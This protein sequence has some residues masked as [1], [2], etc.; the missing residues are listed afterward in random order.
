MT[1][2]FF[3][4]LLGALS[5]LLPHPPNFVPLGAL[6]L[7]AGARL[8]RRWALAVPLAS[9]VVSDFFLDFGA[10]RALITPVRVAVYAT[11]AAMVLIGRLARGEASAARLLVLTVGS[12]VAFFLTTNLAVFLGGALYPRTALGL[13][14][15]Y[16]A[17]V[18]FFWSTLLADLC[19]TGLFFGLDAFSR[20][21]RTRGT[22]RAAAMAAAIAL[23]GVAGAQ[24]QPPVSAS[25]IVTATMTEEEERELGS[26]ATVITRER[27]E[28]SGARTVVELLREV[29]GL[30]VAQQG[31]DGALTS[32]FLR[33]AN[34][35]HLLVLVDGARMNS[36]YFS[37]YDFSSLTTENIERIE[38]VRGPFSALYGSDAIGG[39]VQ[40]F[41]RP[42]SS[43]AAGRATLEGGEQGQRRLSA[44]LSAGEGPFGAAASYSDARSNGPRTNSDWGER[45]GTLRI[46]WRGDHG[47]RVGME[48][49]IRE[50]E[51][52]VPGPVG[53]ESPRAR[54]EDREERLQIPVAFR[55]AAGH[56]ASLLFARVAS[57]RRFENPDF[58]FRS[59]SSPE[60]LQARGTDTFRAG[61]H[62]MTAFASWERGR[63][64]DRSNFG[65]ALDD[66][67]STLWGAGLQDILP[68]ARGLILTAG[69][70][71][72]R[73]SDFGDAWSPRAT[74]AWFDGAGLWKARASAG[75]AFRAPSVGE[76]F[77]PFSGNPDLEPERVTSY[78]AGVERFLGAGGASLG[79]SL[80]W[81]EFRNLIVYE[82]FT[83]LNANVGRARTRGAEVVARAPLGPRAEVNAAY[84][85][86][87][88][89][90]RQTGE[91][92]LRRPRHRASASIAWQPIS[93]WTL[94]P[95]VVFVGRRADADPVT[96]ARVPQPSFL[97]LD[98]FTRYDFGLLEAYARVENLAD[99]PY[100]EVRGYPASG[101]RFSGG[102]EVRF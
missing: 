33:G 78:E 59:Q 82:F 26:A 77:Y 3:L 64:N 90:D 47:L 68:L 88:A 50:S 31:S 7:Y 38:V 51:V 45:S 61:P 12:S 54:Q 32:V 25:V 52:G 10:G 63:V 40:I 80:F 86:L 44:F 23:P 24:S 96:R 11:F 89:E 60:T 101:R 66:H 57:E 41:T 58:D 43:A 83:S 15:C 13:A 69:M 1:T 27:I 75:T 34:T 81:N 92:L 6:A 35:P 42:T 46:D 76:L 4:V 17:A 22:G 73:H 79:A 36:P 16:A 29:P 102:L 85:W 55:P 100:E 37:G 72:D 67:G 30:D 84:T 94:A 62:Q 97:R 20:R 70:R 98:V 14:L 48:G 53:A 56:E 95:R 65:V 8:P 2:A 99:R 93:R 5:R 18:P 39:V 19:G 87:D 21:L 71:Y 9:L 74:I 49:S 91:D 28:A